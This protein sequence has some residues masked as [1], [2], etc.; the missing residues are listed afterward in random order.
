[1]KVKIIEL[2]AQ[3]IK[4][5]IG[6]LA[7]ILTDSVTDGAS[8]SFMAP[9][10]YETAAKF[11]LENVLPEV[12]TGNR[13]LFGAELDGEIVGVV[14]LITATSPNQPHRA[15]IAKMIVHPS[16][17]RLGIGRLLMNQAINHAKEI[18]KTLITLD[19]RK[20]DSAELLYSSVGFITAGVIPDFA[21]DPYGQEC[22]AT[23][24]MF[25]QL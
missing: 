7:R 17:R 18:G 11:W 9:L 21:W 12:L 4:I 20:G 24:Y 25:R 14:Q 2:D 10:A 22:H 3:T 8:I 15:E 16:N 1:M 6:V 19:T 5:K 13:V 23:T